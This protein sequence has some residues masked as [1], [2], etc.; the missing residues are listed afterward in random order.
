MSAETRE[1]ILVGVSL[2]PW[3]I[4]VV[5]VAWSAALS[6]VEDGRSRARARREYTYQ[7]R[8]RGGSSGGRASRRAEIGTER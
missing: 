1:A 6:L 4:F 3:L 2:A 8:E 5:L 7:A